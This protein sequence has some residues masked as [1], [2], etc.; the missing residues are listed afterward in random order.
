M[1]NPAMREARAY[2]PPTAKVAPVFQTDVKGNGGKGGPLTAQTVTGALK[3]QDAIATAPR[4]VAQA[5][6]G[7]QP[8]DDPL[9]NPSRDIS[10]STA[11]TRLQN[12]TAKV[13]A[14]INDAGG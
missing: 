12:R 1:P 13:N 10:L 4:P 11:Q 2:K 8:A 7:A 5:Q 9:N 14:T 3:A 6:V